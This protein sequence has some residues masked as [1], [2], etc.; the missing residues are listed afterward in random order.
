MKIFIS[1]L[2]I[3]FCSNV[4]AKKH[5]YSKEVCTQLFEG[6]QTFLSIADNSWKKNTETD[7]KKAMEM[8]QTAT[9]YTI[10]YNSFCK[11]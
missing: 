7:N 10:I 6:I 1:I 9:N 3:F 11:K 5:K 2:I 4:M 8:V